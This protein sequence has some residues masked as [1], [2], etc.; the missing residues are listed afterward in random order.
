MYDYKNRIK[1]R[2]WAFKIIALNFSFNVL[3]AW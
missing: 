1:K 2:W 3:E